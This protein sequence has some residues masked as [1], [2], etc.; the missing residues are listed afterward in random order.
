MGRL[1]VAPI[2]VPPLREHLEDLPDL[3]AALTR[4]H[5]T[6]GAKVRWLPD[7][8]QTL[9][10]LEWPGN[11]GQLEN[12]VRQVLASCRS[13][14]ISAK[15]LP[16]DVRREAPRRRLSHLER[17]ELD[18]IIGALR[19]AAGNKSEAADHLGISR[20]TLYRRIRAFGLDLGK[21]AF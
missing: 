18:A 1:A 7:A 8:V 21:A 16:E 15:D 10:R 9:T 13:G 20:A 11:I 6:A 4:K 5:T 19:Q 12:L 14:Y 2:K 3:L 17:V